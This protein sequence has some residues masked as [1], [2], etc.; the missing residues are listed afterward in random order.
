MKTMLGP[1]PRDKIVLCSADAGPGSQRTTPDKAKYFF[2]GAPWVGAIRNSAERLGCNF[3]ILTTGHG[4]VNSDDI[5]A[6]YDVHIQDYTQ[7]VSLNWRRTIL[8]LLGNSINSVMLFYAG[9][10][11]RDQYI[12]LLLPI[13]QRLGISLISFGRPN[14]YDID[15]VETFVEMLTRGT[16]PDTFASTLNHP[17]RFEFYFHMV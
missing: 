1:I 11:P 10:C 14:M 16:S 7:Q 8:L 17:E 15:K 13:L 9:G 12:E 4:L 3:V 5:I 6:P 2:V